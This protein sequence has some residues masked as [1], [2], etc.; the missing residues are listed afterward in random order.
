MSAAG[1]EARVAAR[2]DAAPFASAE[3]AIAAG[4]RSFAA[5]A[6]L[7]DRDTRVAAVLLYAWCRHCDDVVDG[8]TLG[9]GA[10]AVEDAGA[11]LDRLYDRTRRALAGE[12]GDEPAFEALRWVVHRHGVPAAHPLALLDGFAMDVHGARYRTLAD[13]L[14]YCYHVAGVV[15][16]MMARVM[17]ARDDATLDRACDLGLAFQLTNIARDVADDA[18]LGRVYLPED[19]LAEAALAPAAAAAAL[20]ADAERPEV[21]ALRARLVAA[22]EPYYDSAL[23]GVARLPFRSAWAVA[24]ARAVYRDIGRGIEA[25]RAGRVVVGRACRAARVAGAALAAATLRGLPLAARYPRRDL[26]QRPA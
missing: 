7:F 24:A 22:A 6:R 15:G 13:T 4:S 18:R 10:R 2:E 25:G 1:L 12:R 14:R 9:H 21:R 26:W 5:A 8:Q 11:R 19:W 16:L 3:Q 23:A 17:G 20:A